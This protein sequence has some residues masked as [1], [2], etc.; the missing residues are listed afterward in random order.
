MGALTGLFQ[1]IDGT[2]RN[3]FAAM[4]QK[5]MNQLLQI[6][7][8]WLTIDQRYHV[9]TKHALQLRLGKKVV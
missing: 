5:V 6:E 2:A 3:H 1:Q 7:N 8:L 9:D 4:T